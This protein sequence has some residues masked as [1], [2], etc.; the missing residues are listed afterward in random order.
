MGIIKDNKVK[1]RCDKKEKNR[2]VCDSKWKSGGKETANF[3]MVADKDGNLVLK[4]F[5][6]PEDLLERSK[7]V[8]SKNVSVNGEKIEDRNPEF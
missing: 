2:V 7:E 4:S 8:V 3:D 5:E 6:G 1:V